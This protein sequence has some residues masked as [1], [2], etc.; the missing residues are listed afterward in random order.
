[1]GV[2]LLVLCLSVLG[3]EE[4]KEP[5][6]VSFDFETWEWAPLSPSLAK[7][8][9]PMRDKGKDINMAV[10]GG[11]YQ[12]WT[13]H[14]APGHMVEGEEAFKGKSLLINNDTTA[15]DPTH[16]EIGYFSA[17]NGLMKPDVEYT[18]EIALKG[19]GN[20]V[21]KGWNEGVN[22]ANGEKKWLGFPELINITLTPEWKVHKGTIKLP[23]Y[24]DPDFRPRPRNGCAIVASPGT[25]IY[26]DEFKITPISP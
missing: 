8:V 17:F 25:R 7:A 14:G 18:Y 21:F 20:F 22:P 2:S 11:S 6:G 16:T 5:A 23:E 10:R 13:H 24:D 4:K 3:S 1:M 9:K 26:V 15:D 19:K 12:R